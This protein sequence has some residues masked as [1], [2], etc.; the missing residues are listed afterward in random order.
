MIDC[1]K[2]DNIDY[3]CTYV[4]TDVQFDGYLSKT[5]RKQFLPNSAVVSHILKVRGKLLSVPI[6]FLTA[7]I[8]V[9]R[10]VRFGD[11]SEM[12]V[13]RLYI[14]CVLCRLSRFI[15]ENVLQIQSFI[16]IFTPGFYKNCVADTGINLGQW[17]LPWEQGSNFRPFCSG[18]WGHFSWLKP[19]G[20]S[21]PTIKM[22]G[23]HETSYFSTPRVEKT[24]AT[25]LKHVSWYS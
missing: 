4:P 25:R 9:E 14:N 15:I 5:Q 1:Y 10:S 18:K 6:N 12:S 8:F 7:K 23:E 3:I 11:Y 2:E 22:S 20:A 17:S 21:Y 19:I 13:W 24:L 16:F